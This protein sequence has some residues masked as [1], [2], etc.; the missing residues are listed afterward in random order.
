VKLVSLPFC[1][2]HTLSVTVKVTA[3]QKQKQKRKSFVLCVH[4]SL[5]DFA[6]VTLVIT[7]GSET[8]TVTKSERVI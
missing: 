4:L 5:S 1:T 8:V 6:G 2:P 7:P 3:G